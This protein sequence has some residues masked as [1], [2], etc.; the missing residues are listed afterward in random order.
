LLKR[1]HAREPRRLVRA[2][3]QRIE[4]DEPANRIEP[5]PPPPVPV[6]RPARVAV[7]LALA[8]KLSEVDEWVRA[9]DAV[10]YGRGFAEKNLRRMVQFA[11]AFS[12][13]EIVA[14]LSRQL[15]W[16]QFVLLLPVKGALAREFY[17][18]M[19][20][21]EGWNVRTLRAKIQSMLFE[22]TSLSRRPEQLAR[23]ELATLELGAGFTTVERQ[24]RITVDKRD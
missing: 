20:R 1:A 6:R 22:R 15:S 5:P 24:K 3:I 10:D 16:S 4:V 21:V 11:E 2:I 18:E 17:A 23:K 19:C 12:D 13:S 14:T 8:H 9:G 7:M